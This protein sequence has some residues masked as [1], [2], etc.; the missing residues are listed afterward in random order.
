MGQPPVLQWFQYKRLRNTLEKYGL[1]DLLKST[2]RGQTVNT[3]MLDCDYSRQDKNL[4]EKDKFTGEFMHE[5][6]RGEYILA[7]ILNEGW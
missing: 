5:Y 4:G 1:H 3:E 7:D 2:A 6:S